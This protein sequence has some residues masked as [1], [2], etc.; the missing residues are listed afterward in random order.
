MFK[1]Y[2]D[3]IRNPPEG[4]DWIIFRDS[5]SALD[6]LQKNL[7]NVE[8]I[9]FDHDLGGD[10]TTRIVASFLEEKAYWEGKKLKI[11][12]KVHSANPVGKAWLQKALDRSTDLI[13]F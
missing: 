8:M 13:E 11:K 6:F 3:D 2:I 4:D 5:E 10:D 12:T 7:N 1:M 9:S